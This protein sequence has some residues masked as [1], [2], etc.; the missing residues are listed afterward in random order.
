MALKRARRPGF[1][2][3]LVLFAALSLFRPVGAI[4][5]VGFVALFIG[6]S[7]FL[8][9]KSPGKPQRL[10]SKKGL[11]YLFYDRAA[12]ELGK[13]GTRML[14]TFL[15]VAGISPLVFIVNLAL[16]IALHGQSEEGAVV[17][18]IALLS[19]VA[20]YVGLIGSLLMSS[21]QL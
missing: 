16:Q 18:F 11:S 19:V 3:L 12:A 7:L 1:I 21:K 17:F 15:L 9:N 6:I 13:R 4:A 8:Y 20:F 2:I 5:F 10:L 14:K